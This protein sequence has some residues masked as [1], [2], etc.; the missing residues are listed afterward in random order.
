MFNSLSNMKHLIY[1]IL[2]ACNITFSQINLVPNPSFENHTICPN[3]GGQINYC[4]NWNNVNLVYGSFTVGTPDYFHLC[5]SGTTVPPNTF[6]GQC[7][8]HTGSAM[9]SLVMYNVPY[10]GYR[11]YMSTALSC[12]MIT[13]NTYT[14][15]FWLTNGLN[16]ISQYRIKNIGIHFSI[17]PLTQ[18]GYSIINAV[19]QVEITG[20]SGSTSWVQYTFTVSPTANWQYLTIGNFRN[21]A[22]NSPTSTY[23]ITTGA[24]SVYANYFFDD[25]EVLT[26]APSG[27]VSLTSSASN[28][29]CFGASN[30]SATVTATGTGNSYLWAPGNYTTATVGNLSAGI[31]TVTVNNGGCNSNT[32]SV[33]IAQPSDL[34]GNLV[35]ITQSVCIGQSVILSATNSGGV[36]SYT[37]NWSNGSLNTT[38]VS[39][40]PSVT[41]VYSYTV[42][43][44]NNC[45]KTQSVQI[46]VDFTTA[47]F[48]NSS[49]SCTGLVT[50][51]NASSNG[52]QFF[53]DF[54][55]GH[56]STSVAYA[57]HSY[58]NSGTYT[59]SLISTSSVGCSDTISKTVT[60]NSN[61][62]YVDFDYLSPSISCSDSVVFNNKSTGAINY[63][64]NFGDGTTSTQTSP[65][66]FYNPGTYLVTLVVNGTGCTDTLVK[67]INIS[68]I[69]N[70]DEN[71]PN[72][73]T[74][75][76]D[77]VNEKFDF[78]MIEKCNDFSFEIFD[79][80][81][82]SILKSTQSHQY[83]WD[84]R[85]TSGE[86]VTDGTYFYIM[87]ISNGTK[88]KGTITLFR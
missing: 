6:A 41:S 16:P 4:T 25:I 20:L 61:S 3:F 46:N 55:D 68:D 44:A 28:V 83:F 66:H 32:L 1:F 64:W 14:V 79:R 34:V 62:I 80:W 73:F 36:P 22:L 29:T 67:E 53:W 71:I 31:Y 49:S 50:F 8:P 11:E 57:Y 60:V 88:L 84:G 27:T 38:S 5:G 21:D 10:P 37:T 72:V 48:F 24:P 13:G 51:T 76:G 54:G 87:N 23:S 78:R 18:S 19:P 26:S 42:T 70:T 30:G 52:I 15:S 12:P 2:F 75:N 7:N 86:A 82:L 58:S 59:V 9:T 56:N 85:T 74:P 43:D 65:L 63:N 45:T 40:S 39:V 81:G 77:G 33:N 69:I 17:A 47:D 35:A